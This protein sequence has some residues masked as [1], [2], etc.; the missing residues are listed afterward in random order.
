M[1][2]LVCGKHTVISAYDSKRV[3]EIYIKNAKDAELFKG[4]KVEQKDKSFFKKKFENLNILHQGFAALVSPIKKYDVEYFFQKN[5]LK[6]IALQG[7]EDQRNIGSIIRS[8]AAFN[9]DGLIIEKKNFNESSLLMNKTHAGNIDHIKIIIVTNLINL[10]KKIKKKNC[11]IYCLDQNSK[12]DIKNYDFNNKSL[13]IFGNESKGIKQYIIKECD[14]ALKIKINP[15]V[16]SLN[17]S[18]AVAIALSHL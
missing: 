13:L 3:K 6:L 10:I 14:A 17:L 8:C 12:A 18:N 7:I 16:E 2:Y 4:I 9:V 1:D 5:N 11:F 15:D